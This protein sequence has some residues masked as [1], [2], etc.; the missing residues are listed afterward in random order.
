M[1]EARN[2]KK[3]EDKQSKPIG[4]IISQQMSEPNK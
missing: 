1:Q 4:V 3:Q 2:N